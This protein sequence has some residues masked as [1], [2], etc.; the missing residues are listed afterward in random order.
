MTYTT[1]SANVSSTKSIQYSFRLTLHTYHVIESLFLVF[2]VYMFLSILFCLIKPY[3]EKLC[4]EN[5]KSKNK[6]TKGI[7][8]S[9]SASYDENPSSNTGGKVRRRHKRIRQ[10][11]NLTMMS[12]TLTMSSLILIR[13]TIDLWA[14]WE[15]NNFS[16]KAQCI[17]HTACGLLYL[18]SALCLYVFLWIRQRAFYAHPVLKHLARPWIIRFS[19]SVL[20]CIVGVILLATVFF[21]LPQITSII[22]I[23]ANNYTVSL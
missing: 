9:N 22:E 15:Q 23:K 4:G 20:V 19:W 2:A 3:T 14:Y 13:V 16:I 8:E 5:G 7:D 10:R 11:A 12:L 21:F 1:A 17:R 18:A 6:L